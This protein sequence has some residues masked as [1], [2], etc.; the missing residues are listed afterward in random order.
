MPVVAYSFTWNSRKKRIQLRTE[1]RNTNNKNVLK[2]TVLDR[3]S[4]V[5]F[6]MHICHK[7]TQRVL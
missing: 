3:S 4:K 1:V 6:A 7:E 5:H 2:H